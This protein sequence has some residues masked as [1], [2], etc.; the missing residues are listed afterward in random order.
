MYAA[1]HCY[2]LPSGVLLPS[3][4]FS[5]TFNKR[6]RRNA[7][8]LNLPY[9]EVTRLILRLLARNFPEKALRRR[10]LINNPY[11]IV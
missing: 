3:A 4:R 2:N 6:F 9:G 8:I 10:K 5:F 1:E 7:I 11:F